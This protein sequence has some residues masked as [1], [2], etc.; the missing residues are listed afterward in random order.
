M[1]E[2]VF[3]L[4]ETIYADLTSKIDNMDKKLKELKINVAT[5]RK[6]ITRGWRANT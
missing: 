3:N 2:K 6:Y 4:L 5:K 1:D